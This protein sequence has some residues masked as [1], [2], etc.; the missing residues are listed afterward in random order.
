MGDYTLTIDWGDGTVKTMELGI[1]M[2][3]SLREQT[4]QSSGMYTVTVSRSEKYDTKV[5]ECKRVVKGRCV[6]IREV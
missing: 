1:E 2:S 5:Q 4:Y 3:R 6:G